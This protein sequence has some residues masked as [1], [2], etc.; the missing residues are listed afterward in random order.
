MSKINTTF[1]GRRGK[2]NFLLLFL[3][4]ALL[5]AVGV[6][7]DA[8]AA[9]EG[10]AGPKGEQGPVG[11]AG[12]DGSMMYADEGAPTD[13]IGKVGDYYLDQNTGGLYGPK[14][15]EGWNNNPIIVLMG[16][17]GQDGADGQ[18]GTDGTDGEDGSRIYA[19]DGPP[20]EDL[21]KAGDFYLDKTNYDLY[22]PKA[23]FAMIGTSFWPAPINLKG[24]DGN[25]NVTRYIFRGHDFT[26]SSFNAILPNIDR[27][28]MRQS[29]WLIYLVYHMEIEYILNEM[30]YYSVPGYGVGNQTY[31]TSQLYSIIE[32]DIITDNITA[33]YVGLAVST[34]DG[35]AEF[36]TQIEV[37]RIRAANTEDLRP[38]RSGSSLIIPKGLDTSDYEA[39]AEYYGF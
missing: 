26:Q 7:C 35:P 9:V 15:D 2:H 10:P 28:E 36:Y 4:F 8:P 32:Q 14:T 11:P 37:V 38:K 12:E 39:V 1:I 27:A 29:A 5:V 6:S 19:G 20:S 22:G 3:S 18:D 31:Y 17:D 25:A 33:N 24:A 30:Y 13:D 23:A 34:V 16:E 21:G